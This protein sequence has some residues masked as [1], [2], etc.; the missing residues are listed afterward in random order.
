MRSPIMSAENCRIAIWADAT[1]PMFDAMA[2]M[3]ARDSSFSSPE[4]AEDETE[5]S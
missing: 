3:A 4:A 1:V 2:A 5:D